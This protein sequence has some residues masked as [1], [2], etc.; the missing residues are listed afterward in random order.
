MCLHA[1]MDEVIAGNRRNG[2]DGESEGLQP[3][4]VV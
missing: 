4:A 2:G 3:A 1:C